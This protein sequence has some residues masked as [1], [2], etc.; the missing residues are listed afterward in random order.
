MATLLAIDFGTHRCSMAFMGPEGA[1]VITSQAGTPNIPAAVAF[2][3][4][5]VLAG[6]DAVDQAVDN[7]EGTVFSIKRLLGRKFQS[8]EMQWLAGSFPYPI[9]AANNGDA[10]LHVCLLYTSPS[11][12]DGLLSRMPSSA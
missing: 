9:V 10:H 12:R 11:P 1:Q 5:G 4:D 7:P 8:P 3:A 2:T 6:Q